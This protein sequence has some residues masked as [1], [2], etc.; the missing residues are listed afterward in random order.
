MKDKSNRT[1]LRLIRTLIIGAASATLVLAH[2]SCL[3]LGKKD[4]DDGARIEA[5]E[6]KKKRG[7]L[8][9]RAKN[10]NGWIDEDIQTTRRDRYAAQNSMDFTLT[11]PEVDPAPTPTPATRNTSPLSPND[12]IDLEPDPTIGSENPVAVARTPA[13]SEPPLRLPSSLDDDFPQPNQPT[14]APDP[15][16]SRPVADEDGFIPLLQPKL[17]RAESIEEPPT[18]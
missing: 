8:F 5:D 4:S 18:E 2:T 16:P 3:G 10:R 9:A 13:P 12:P 14:A 11:N 6:P 17:P 15:V 1:E 7:S